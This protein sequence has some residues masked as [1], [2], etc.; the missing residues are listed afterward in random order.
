MARPG[1]KAPKKAK[2]MAKGHATTK[3]E[4]PQKPSAMK[5][6]LS[7]RTQLVRSV[8]REVVGFAPYERKLIELLQAGGA[9][10]DKKALKIA[11]KRLGTHRRGTLKRESIREVVQKMRQ[12]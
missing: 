4:K 1:K 5:G 11:K 3:L 8:I 6:R 10:E 9:K 2:V 12:R 7:K